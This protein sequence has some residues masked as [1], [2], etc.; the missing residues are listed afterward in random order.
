[1][2]IDRSET[3][4]RSHDF[5]TRSKCRTAEWQNLEVRARRIAAFKTAALLRYRD[6]IARETTSKALLRAAQN[7]EIRAKFQRNAEIARASRGPGSANGQSDRPEYKVWDA[8]VQRCTNP[9]SSSF[10]NYG[11][12]GIRVAAAWRGYGGFAKFFAH[13]GARPTPTHTL[14][15]IDNNGNYEPGNV[16]W[17]T[18]LEQ[19]RNSRKVHMVT[20][21]G[22]T[23]HLAEWARRIGITP[24]A[25]EYRLRRNFTEDHLLAPGRGPRHRA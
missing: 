1:M 17:A 2:P 11:G 4:P 5:E 23:L 9:K 24:P 25:L 14:D 22:E 7:P 13:I 20:I 8:L 6:P 16:R 18:R 15:R 19:S 21:R 10:R 3:V 12:R